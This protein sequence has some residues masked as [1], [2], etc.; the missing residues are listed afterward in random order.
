MCFLRGLTHPPLADL[1]DYFLLKMFYLEGFKCL[2]LAGRLRQQKAKLPAQNWQKLATRKD[3]FQLA[4]K[5]NLSS[6]GLANHAMPFAEAASMLSGPVKL[7]LRPGSS[8]VFKASF[9][10]TLNSLWQISRVLFL[11]QQ[12]VTWLQ[13]TCRSLKTHAPKQ[14]LWPQSG[15]I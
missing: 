5:D 14:V 12:R 8:G 4:D 1:T 3:A 15:C 2:D 6:V 7:I 11:G 9:S 13:T 10:A